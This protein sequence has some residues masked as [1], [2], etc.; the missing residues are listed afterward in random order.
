[1]PPCCHSEDDP[2]RYKPDAIAKWLPKLNYL[3]YLD[4]DLV[5]KDASVDFARRYVGQ[6]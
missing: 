5:V 6:V 4:M 1:M 2:I 3:V